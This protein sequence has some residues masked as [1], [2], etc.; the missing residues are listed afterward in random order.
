MSASGHQRPRIGISA[1]LVEARWGVW[2]QEAALL[3]MSYLRAI[4][5]AGGMALVIPPDPGLVE[6]PDEA[7]ELLDGLILSGGADI[8]PATYGAAREPQ[9]TRTEPERDALELS[10]VRRALELGIPVLGICRGMQML[11]VACGGTLHQHL[12]QLVGHDEHRRHLGTFQGADHPVQLRPGSLAARAAGEERHRTLSHHHQGIDGLGE[13]LE[14]TG[15]STLDDLP[16]AIEIP[17]AEYALGVQ[18]HP[19]ADPASQIVASLVRAARERL[20]ERDG[21]SA[22]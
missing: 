2:E 5:R 9:T 18:W 22:A 20:M 1:N 13:G 21:A 10:L 8:D 3:P 14:I 7:L 11:N 4:Q 15:Y 17:G 19:E 12:P 6:H 16:E